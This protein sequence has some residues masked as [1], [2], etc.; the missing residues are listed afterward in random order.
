[1]K[2]K[3]TLSISEARKKFFTIAEDVQ[4][5]GAYYTLTERGRPKAVIVSADRFES[6]MEDRTRKDLPFLLDD[7][8]AGKGFVV[9]ETA[10]QP[11]GRAWMRVRGEKKGAFVV[12]E[13][14]K[15]LYLNGPASDSL[16]HAK[17]LAKAQ[18]YVELVE[19]YRYPLETI[20]VGRCMKVGGGGSRRYIEADII[21]EDQRDGILLLFAVAA[22]SA[23]ISHMSEALQDLFE[24]ASAFEN[25][26]NTPVFLIYYTRSHE[27]GKSYRQCTVIDQGKYAT[28]E[29]WKQAGEPRETGIPTYQSF[30][31]AKKR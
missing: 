10:M 22:P 25:D 6:L 23:Y 1:M 18:L 15:A 28:L 26:R 31:V 24:L 11:Y 2:M 12:R 17:E 7:G 5:P 3:S 19:K 4:K 29:A 14:P 13:V 20:E 27:K 8:L 30:F 9:R 21:V 16:Y